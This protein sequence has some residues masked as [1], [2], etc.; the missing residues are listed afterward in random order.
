MLNDQWLSPESALFSN[1]DFDTERLEKEKSALA[2]WDILTLSGSVQW[3]RASRSVL[4][5]IQISASA[6]LPKAAEHT[7]TGPLHRVAPPC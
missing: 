1:T 6:V 7:Q 4:S 5:A 2:D 3:Y